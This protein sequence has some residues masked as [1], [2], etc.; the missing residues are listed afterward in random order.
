METISR[1][2]CG[3]CEKFFASNTTF[4]QHR[5]GSIKDETRRCMTTEEML[6]SGM[7]TEK[8]NV[9]LPKNGQITFE[10][11]DVWYDVA[12][13]EVVRQRFHQE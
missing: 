9:K 5:T 1:I 2:Q 8:L 11:H 13:R 3:G 12:G 7:A 10:E 6:A 4:E